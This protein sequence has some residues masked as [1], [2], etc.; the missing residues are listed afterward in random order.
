[1]LPHGDSHVLTLLGLAFVSIPGRLFLVFLV[2][3]EPMNHRILLL[4]VGLQFSLLSLTLCSLEASSGFLHGLCAPRM[5]Q[6]KLLLGRWQNFSPEGQEQ[7]RLQ[8]QCRR[9]GL[10]TCLSPL[11]GTVLLF[12][13]LHMAP[14]LHVRPW[15]KL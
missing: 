8:G 4:Y 12:R 13:S 5:K 15:R 6:S 3:F 9:R 14:A 1:M 7:G 2:G 10:T 11:P